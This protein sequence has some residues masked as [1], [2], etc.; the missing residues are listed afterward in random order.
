MQLAHSRLPPPRSVACAWA[1]TTMPCAARTVP[2]AIAF[3]TGSSQFQQPTGSIAAAAVVI[4]STLAGWAEANPSAR[5]VTNAEASAHGET[6]WN[7]ASGTASIPAL[8]AGAADLDGK[9]LVAS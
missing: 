1:V 6:V 4:T 8:E 2:A 7:A 3:F 9:I 5:I